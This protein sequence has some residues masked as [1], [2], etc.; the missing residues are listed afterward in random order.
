MNLY[1]VDLS[2]VGQHFHLVD[3]TENT[4]NYIL[5]DWIMK[6]LTTFGQSLDIMFVF[7]Q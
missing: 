1:G 2:C 5:A 3:Y 6:I 7:C 4:F